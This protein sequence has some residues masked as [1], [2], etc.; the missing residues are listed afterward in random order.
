[1][2]HLGSWVGCHVQVSFFHRKLLFNGMCFLW[3]PY[4]TPVYG[5]IEMKVLE[6]LLEMWFFFKPSASVAFRKVKH[7]T[8]VHSYVLLVNIEHQGVS[9]ILT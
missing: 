9:I 1:M 3:Q 8:F 2:I 6:I 7:I 4:I 5:F